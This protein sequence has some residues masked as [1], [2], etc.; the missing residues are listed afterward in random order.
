MR[1]RLFFVLFCLSL[2]LTSCSSPEPVKTDA[3]G[4]LKHD[5]VATETWL[6]VSREA[7]YH[8]TYTRTGDKIKGKLMALNNIDDQMSVDGTV[9]GNKIQFTVTDQ[10]NPPQEFNGT[11][12]DDG[13]SISGPCSFNGNWGYKWSATN[14]ND[15]F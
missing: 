9:K 8:L 12:S 1:F 13:Q 2:I 15:Q 6:L 3:P 10:L 5:A 4:Y 11:I 14:I 7:A